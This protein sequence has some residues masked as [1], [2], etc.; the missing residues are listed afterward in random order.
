MDKGGED[1]REKE[2]RSERGKFDERRANPEG[3]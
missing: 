3:K 2:K 1:Q